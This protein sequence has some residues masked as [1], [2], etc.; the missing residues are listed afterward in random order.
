M[1][2]EKKT[3]VWIILLSILTMIT[4]GFVGIILLSA[5]S[6]GFH[7]ESA[8]INGQHHHKTELTATTKI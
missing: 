1:I 5:C 7:R 6:M 4:I 2:N 8:V 3:E